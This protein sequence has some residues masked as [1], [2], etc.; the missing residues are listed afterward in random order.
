MNTLKKTLASLALLATVFGC[1]VF[2]DPTPELISFQMS[3]E[4]GS[5]VTVIYSKSFV[6]AV[7]EAGVTR[8]EIFVADTVVHTFPIDTVISIELER[9]FFAQVATAPT[10]TLSVSVRVDVDGRNQLS[11]SGSIFPTTPWQYVY[12]YNVRFTDI[13]EVV[14]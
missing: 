4:A 9:Q 6:A 5:Q 10:D 2:R 11:S 8:V 14:I 3:G 13:V 7:N 1:D 12:Q